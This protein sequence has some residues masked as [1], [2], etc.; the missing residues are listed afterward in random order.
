MVPEAQGASDL[1]LVPAR[2]ALQA[3]GIAAEE[4]DFLVFATMTPDVTFPGSGCFL[5]DKLGCGTAGALDI[6]GQCTGFLM[7]LMVADSFL[8]AG[9]YERVLIASAEVHSSWLDYGERGARVAALYGDGAAVAVLG[10]GSNGAGLGAVVCHAD[11]RMYDKFWCEYPASRVHPTRITLEHFRAGGHFPAID[12]AAV[13]EFGREQ[14][15]A[16]VREAVTRAAVDIEAVDAFVLSHLMPEVVAAAA[17]ELR[18]PE[19]KVICAG[20]RHGHLTAAGLPVALSEA[21]SAGRLG[22]G[23]RVC[24]AT[25]G[26]G[27]TSGAAVLTL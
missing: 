17:E 6:R 3:A 11:G 20:E 19:A 1:A 15:P 7:A 10:R 8:A 25:C 22:A 12:F 24:L 13:E 23:S 2:A 16:A 4:V 18:L 21:M 9:V 27:F 26:A 14:L 5:Q